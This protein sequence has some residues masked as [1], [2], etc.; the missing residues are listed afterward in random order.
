MILRDATSEDTPAICA[1]W[2]PVIEN[3][4]A[5]FTTALKTPNGLTS[6][7]MDKRANGFGFF[8]AEKK[9]EILGFASYGQFRGGP[10][11]RHSFEHSIVLS[12]KAH[13]QG[14]GR[15]MMGHLESH[16]IRNKG[17]ILMAGVS[18]ENLTGIAFHRRIGFQDTAVLPQVGRKFG[19]WMDLHLLHKVLSN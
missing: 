17:H 10:G 11:Y 5:T 12:P 2:N 6:E 7:I 19:R 8:V 14:L 16:A 13:G 3:T 15:A 9:G 1:I 4:A 18:S